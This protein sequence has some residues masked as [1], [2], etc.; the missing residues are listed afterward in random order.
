MVTPA[1]SGRNVVMVMMAYWYM[2]WPHWRGG[3]LWLVGGDP[4]G[5]GSELLVVVLVNR[6]TVCST[7]SSPWGLT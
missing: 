2:W 1:G 5:S 4:L 6:A 3:G 7:I